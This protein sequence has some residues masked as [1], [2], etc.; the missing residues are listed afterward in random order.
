MLYLLAM[1]FAF[2]S[3]LVVAIFLPALA[4]AEEKPAAPVR[5][6]DGQPSI[7]WKGEVM[8]GHGCKKGKVPGLHYDD[9]MNAI[10]LDGG[11]FALRVPKGWSVTSERPNLM[12]LWTSAR[13]DGVRPVFEVFVTP[14]CKQVDAL[15]ASQ[16]VAARALAGLAPSEAIIEQVA[17]GKWGAGL[18]GPVGTSL[19][20]FDV[21]LTTPKGERTMVL[22]STD[23]GDGKTFT[24]RA[25][26]ACPREVAKEK[27]F[28]AC[29]E[30]YFE[31]LKTDAE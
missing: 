10:V 23:V 22:Y 13:A 25:A 3:L 2:Q 21:V 6:P 1:N 20:L 24:I 31:M 14:K 27:G 11:G 8:T 18:G 4:L 7:D 16:R 17:K 15:M 30:T 5:A 29:E 28:G 19:I 9:K 12:L 26:A